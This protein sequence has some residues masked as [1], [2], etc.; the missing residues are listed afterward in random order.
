MISL[1]HSTITPKNPFFSLHI[2]SRCLDKNP[3]PKRSEEHGPLASNSHEI[4]A[5]PDKT[6][7]DLSGLLLTGT[8][9]STTCISPTP[10]TGS[11]L[12]PPP[13]EKLN[14]HFL[15]SHLWPLVPQFERRLLPL[16]SSRTHE[17]MCT[18]ADTHFC[19]SHFTQTEI[20]M[21]TWD[22]GSSLPPL[23]PH[24]SAVS[25]WTCVSHGLR[26][27][28]PRA[29]LFPPPQKKTQQPGS[30]VVAF[31]PGIKH[32]HHLL[33]KSDL[34]VGVHHLPCVRPQ[35]WNLC[36]FLCVWSGT[37]HM[38]LR[39]QNSPPMFGRGSE[40]QCVFQNTD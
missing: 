15:R 16:S 6:W 11:P 12:I 14:V 17:N 28:P 19:V 3:R 22:L 24:H 33:M 36:E 34:E 18:Q 20:H 7:L 26:S 40:P 29:I 13:W 27:N 35:F 21:H 9:S 31:L 1:A 30:R 37:A 8:F 10:P 2:T 23:P 32:D 25:T 4:V 39:F 38:Q 5:E